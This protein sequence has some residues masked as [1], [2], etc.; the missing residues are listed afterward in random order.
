MYVQLVQ[1][2]KYRYPWYVHFWYIPIRNFE[3]T[4]SK[5][6]GASSRYGENMEERQSISVY[7][8]QDLPV[9]KIH[10]HE[11]ETKE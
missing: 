4:K 6:I 11:F 8:L 10:D 7:V 9:E 2:Y 5:V 1:I 3:N